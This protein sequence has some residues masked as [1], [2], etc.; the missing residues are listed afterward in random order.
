MA[1]EREI[2]ALIHEH[3]FG[4]KAVFYKGPK[5]CWDGW[6]DGDPDIEENCGQFYDQRIKNKLPRYSTNIADAW[7]VVEKMKSRL[8]TIDFDGL[9]WNVSMFGDGGPEASHESAPMAIC[10]AALKSKGVEVEGERK[11]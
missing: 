1:S 11:T 8:P 2:D 10:L 4:K 6:C 9:E 7:Q 5:P 3:V